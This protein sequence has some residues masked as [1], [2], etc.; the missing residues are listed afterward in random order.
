MY[1]L[2]SYSVN[3]V[4]IA[5]RLPWASPP[6]PLGF[7]PP[8]C[9]IIFPLS[10]APHSE[11]PDYGFLL[12]FPK[13]PSRLGSTAETIETLRLKA[14]GRGPWCPVLLS[15]LSLLLFEDVTSPG[16]HSSL[17]D[18]GDDPVTSPPSRP[19][20][21]VRQSSPLD[22]RLPARGNLPFLPMGYFLWDTLCR[23][24]RKL[25]GGI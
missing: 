16:P 25:Y 12:P 2:D 1:L 10:L 22:L 6:S 24:G 9:Q 8:Q 7:L 21:S 20:L 23:L 19:D 14:G 17:R 5:Y 3:K 4:K 11:M 13:P 18:P 15:N